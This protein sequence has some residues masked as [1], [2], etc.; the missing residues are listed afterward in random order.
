M[1][2]KKEYAIHISNCKQE[3]NH[4]LVL[5]KVHQ[6]IKFNKKAW[7]KSYIDMNTKLR[8]NP[9]NDFKNNF[10]K[11]TNK[12]QFPEKQWKIRNRRDIKLITTKA[13]RNHQVLEPN[14]QQQIILDNLLAIKMKR[15]RIL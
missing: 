11:L 14:Y 15:I 1:H 8:K 6:V 5:Q 4:G 9:E 13:R 7:L 3:L 10:F 12:M 2:D